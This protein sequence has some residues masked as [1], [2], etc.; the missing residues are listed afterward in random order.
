MLDEV[1]EAVVGPVDVL[2]H[3]HERMSFG[4]SLEEPTPRC[5]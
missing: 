3:E 2:E 4:E 5:E 1:E